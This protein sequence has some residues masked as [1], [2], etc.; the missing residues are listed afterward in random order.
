M[1]SQAPAGS[2]ADGDERGA[3][4][5]AGGRGGRGGRGRLGD[6]VG[7]RAAG[8]AAVAERANGGV[9]VAGAKCEV[10]RGLGQGA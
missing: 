6:D 10:R 4:R 9:A 5:D 8:D 2:V 1:R 3:G 7:P